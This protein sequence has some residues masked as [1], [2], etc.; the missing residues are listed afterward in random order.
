MPES[1]TH[2][3]SLS[4]V[5]NLDIPNRLYLA[6]ERLAKIKSL[7]VG[8]S[9]Y[10]RE[11]LSRYHEIDSLPEEPEKKRL[12]IRMTSALKEELREGADDHDMKPAEYGRRLLSF[13]ITQELG[14]LPE[15]DSRKLPNL[16]KSFLFIGTIS[17]NIFWT[18]H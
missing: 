1:K 8:V 9:S 10:A 18:S 14:S 4:S 7:A 15:I 13:A 3:E 16:F 6:L 11:L 2:K 17:K 5:Y 12:S